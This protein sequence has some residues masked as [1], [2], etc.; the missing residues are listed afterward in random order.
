VRK[1]GSVSSKPKLRLRNMVGFMLR[2]RNWIE[3]TRAYA[4]GLPV[5][6]IHPWALPR[7]TASD[8]DGAEF[9]VLY[10]E[11]WKQDIYRCRHRRDIF[12]IRPD[13]L[14]L[15]VG[16]NVGLF[17]LLAARL[18][19]RGR[20]LALEPHPANFMRLKQHVAAAGVT[21][22]A[23]LQ[24]AVGP[25]PGLQEL[26]CKTFTKH[27]LQLPGT[28]EAQ[29][30]GGSDVGLQVQVIRLSDLIGPSGLSRVDYLKVDTEGSELAILESL[31]QH[32]AQ[33]VHRIV[34]EYHD[35]ASKGVR[36]RIAA[37]L[38]SLGF[39]I[40]EMVLDQGLGMFYGSKENDN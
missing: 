25:E 20:V 4:R 12:H 3:V 16:A 27:S 13:D 19:R 11:I 14:V 18:A 1:E 6:A 2:Y 30:R 32:K 33:L 34:L 15:D 9:L 36:S 39:K 23:L 5:S 37:L 38:R 26:R 24:V 40:E 22:V 28:G 35:L 21:N 17:T 8:V 29:Q 31:P 7:L 10:N